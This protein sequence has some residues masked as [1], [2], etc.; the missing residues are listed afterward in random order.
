M[1][2][3]YAVAK[4]IIRTKRK[5][6][7]I[8]INS[9]QFPKCWSEFSAMKMGHSWSTT[10]LPCWISKPFYKL[11]NYEGFWKKRQPQPLELKS[12][13]GTHLPIF[14]PLPPPSLINVLMHATFED[15]KHYIYTEVTWIIFFMSRTAAKAPW[16]QAFRHQRTLPTGY[17]QKH[18]HGT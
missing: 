4:I 7:E 2:H 18:L 12:I 6:M 15:T 8:A 11:R 9:S 13:A 3:S 17:K 10:H 16:K 1:H 14:T 5:S